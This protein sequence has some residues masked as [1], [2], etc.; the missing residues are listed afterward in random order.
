[1]TPRYTIEAYADQAIPDPE[2][3]WVRYQDHV[4]A[5]DEAREAARRAINRRRQA[6]RER[7]R[8]IRQAGVE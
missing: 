8:T 1:M 3:G 6:R 7:Q 4:A 5:V 2:G